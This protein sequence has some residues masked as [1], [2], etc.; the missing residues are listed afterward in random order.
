M[1]DSCLVLDFDGTILDTE[2]PQFLAWAELWREFGHELSVADWQVHIGK[3]DAFDPA[4]E[5]ANR[6]GHQIT[7]SRHVERRRRRAELQALTGLRN[8]VEE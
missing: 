6:T 1:S 2:E 8:G 4:A 7:P 3:L 5:L